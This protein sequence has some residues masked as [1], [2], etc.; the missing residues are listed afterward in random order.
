MSDGRFLD[1]R[2]FSCDPNRALFV[3]SSA[4]RPAVVLSSQTLTDKVLATRDDVA[5]V[6]DQLVQKNKAS[7]WKLLIHNFGLSVTNLTS[8]GVLNNQQT[9]DQKLLAV[10]FRFVNMDPTPTLRHLILTL[11]EATLDDVAVVLEN[12]AIKGRCKLQP[13]I[14]PSMPCLKHAVSVVNTRLAV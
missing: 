14:Y 10:L 9:D 3:R 11:R 1:I 2:Y 6:H 7:D 12:Q 4:C 13:D 8:D 5:L